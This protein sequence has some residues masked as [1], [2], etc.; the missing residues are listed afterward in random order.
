MPKT[1]R[2]Q[3]PIYSDA[4]DAIRDCQI[5]IVDGIYYLTGT[6]PPTWT[7]PNPGVKLYSSPDLLHWKFEKFLLR[8]EQFAA[9][10]WSRDRFW[11]PEIHARAGKFYLTY[12]C[13]N[14][15]TRFPRSLGLA[16]ADQVAG[17]YQ[18]LSREKPLIERG[19]D[20][21]LFTDDDGQSFGYWTDGFHLYG[22]EIDLDAG[23]PVGAPFNC[24]RNENRKWDGIG[25]EGP[26]VIKRGGI[27]YLFYSSWTR[28][29]EIGYAVATHPRGP[30]QKSPTNPIFGAQSREICEFNKME[31]TGNPASPFIAVGHNAI[32]TGPDGRDWIV[33]HYQEKDGADSLGFDPLRIENGE[34]KSDGPAWTEQVIEIG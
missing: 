16:V 23:R 4:I 30:W 14:E 19:W 15:T 10:N 11:A 8:R 28:G 1:F 5:V 26:F 22:Q 32:F 2:Y 12:T 33:C 31:F 21:T 17:E 25:V 6:C 24:V 34:I 7:G 18:V 20:L 9:D 13:W 29:Y 3:N 27:Y